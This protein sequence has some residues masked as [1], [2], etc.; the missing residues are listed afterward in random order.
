MHP[1]QPHR[2]RSK[3]SRLARTKSRHRHDPAS[4]S[5]SAHGALRP[6][7]RTKA[8]GPGHGSGLY[9]RMSAPG[10]RTKLGLVPHTPYGAHTRTRGAHRPMPPRERIIDDGASATPGSAG[11][12]RTTWSAA[13]NPGPVPSPRPSPSR[14][15]ARSGRLG[16]HCCANAT[17]E[18]AE[19]AVFSADCC[20]RQTPMTYTPLACFAGTSRSGRAPEDF[21]FGAAGIISR[22]YCQ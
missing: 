21:G 10:E 4:G 16:P 8:R 15:P 22:G 19:L 13:G 17:L 12:R 6:P 3:L 5:S 7:D 9:R 1:R 18:G 20:K 2:R 11:H 14:L